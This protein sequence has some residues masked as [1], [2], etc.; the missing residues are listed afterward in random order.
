[1]WWPG[2]LPCVEFRMTTIQRVM[3]GVLLVTVLAIA[4]CGT[5]GPID[6]HAVAGWA[7]RP[8]RIIMLMV[9]NRPS[10]IRPS[11][12]DPEMV[13][14]RKSSDR[15]R[16]STCFLPAMSTRAA[17]RGV[18]GALILA[19]VAACTQNT[20]TSNAVEDYAGQLRSIG[21]ISNVMDHHGPMVEVFLLLFLQKKKRWL[22]LPVVFRVEGGRA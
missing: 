2:L 22:P 1:M 10:E 5:A 20:I 8:S 11:D 21:I 9:S 7:G 3:R 16:C 19:A 13:S 4:G 6:T 15:M 14:F 17:I 18:L 12:N